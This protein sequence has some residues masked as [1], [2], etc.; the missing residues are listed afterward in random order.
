[1]S[2][3]TTFLAMVAVPPFPG[4][5]KTLWAVSQSFHA[6]ACSRAPFPMTRICMFLMATTKV[7]DA[8]VLLRNVERF[9]LESL[10]VSRRVLCPR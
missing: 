2:M 6:R 7:I 1:M 4:A 3:F 10:L 5:T 8:V 9:W